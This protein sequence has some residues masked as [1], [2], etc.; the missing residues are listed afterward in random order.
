M[1]TLSKIETLTIGSTEFA[2]NEIIPVKYTCDGEN[3][4]PPLTIENIPDGTKSLALIVDDPD[5]SNG[6][7]VHWIVWNI[8]PQEMI[9]ENSVPGV[10]GRNGFGDFRYKGPCPPQGI[11][12]YHFK[13]YA[14]DS[15]LN[16]GQGSD[17]MQLEKSM[18]NHIIGKGE[19][20]V[21]YSKRTSA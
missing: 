8:K 4:N 19:L 18:Q 9:L 16:L 5:A 7:F 17:K 6:N 13:I 14:L 15:L 2:P 1:P 12:H 10:E 20:I 3:I 11:H 21:L